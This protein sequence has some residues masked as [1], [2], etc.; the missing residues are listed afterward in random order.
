MA[1]AFANVSKPAENS[2]LRSYEA[3]QLLHARTL[4]HVRLF[5]LLVRVFTILATLRF[6]IVA[7]YRTRYF[8]GVAMRGKIFAPRRCGCMNDAVSFIEY[9]ATRGDTFFHAASANPEER[10]SEHSIIRASIIHAGY[11]KKCF[12]AAYARRAHSH[13]DQRITFRSSLT[14]SLSDVK[15]FLS[16]F[17]SRYVFPHFSRSVSIL[18]Q[19]EFSGTALLTCRIHFI[20]TSCRSRSIKGGI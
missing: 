5:L 13:H 18:R 8:F 20:F 12:R 3:R 6:I 17:V 14:S 10:S 19:R 1:R 16:S 15:V 4:R 9:V 2:R 7:V 11:Y